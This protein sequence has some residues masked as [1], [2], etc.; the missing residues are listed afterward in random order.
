MTTYKV[1]VEDYIGA[2]VS[3]TSALSEWLTAGARTIINLLPENKL[4]KYA[5]DVS[6]TSAGLSMQDKRIFNILKSGY[7]CR[8]VDSGL[9]AWV[10]NSGS[11]HYALAIEPVYL[12]DNGL[13][14]IYSTGSATTGTASAVTY[15]SVG[16]GDIAIAN[17]PNELEQAVVL[18]ASMNEILQLIGAK[19]VE[20]NALSYSAPTAPTALSAPSFTWSDTTYTSATYSNAAYS[21]ASASTA[22][23]VDAVI[24]TITSTAID[25][26]GLT[27]PTYTKPVSSVSYT[28]LG[29]YIAD[30]SDL[31]KAESE[32]NQQK[33]KLEQLQM[34]LYNELNK[35]NKEKTAFD[36]YL[37]Q[38]I[39]NAKLTQ[40]RLIAQSQIQIDLNKFNEA[41]ALDTALENNR[42][43]LE[44]AIKNKDM[45]AQVDLQNKAKAME[46]DSVNR[47]KALE[48]DII[49]KTNFLREQIEEYAAKVQRFQSESMQYGAE[50]NNAVMSFGKNIEKKMGEINT[51]L[52]FF[53]LI[54]T[55]Y[56]DLL[57]VHL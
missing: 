2:T 54:K 28:N 56:T 8:Y 1:R 27:F 40:E 29:T 41:K 31:D 11:I 51:L 24:S 17:F 23:W 34:E 14:Y 19:N 18:Y 3:D 10:T 13:L 26:S 7:K 35:Y 55:E 36:A 50:V 25:I 44:V 43:A 32:N 30:G 52:Q 15:P 49:N 37:T 22:S 33:T 16:C 47:S 46:V 48:A 4:E 5:T 45:T 21:D 53:T 42:Q 6:I 20:I 39:E 57:K 38:A 9:K 12:Y